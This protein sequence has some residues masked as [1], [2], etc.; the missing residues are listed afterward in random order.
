MYLCGIATRLNRDERNDDRI[1]D[2][3]LYGEFEVFIQSARPIRA[4][5]LRTLSADEKRIAHWY[6]LN[7][8]PQLEPYRR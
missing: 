2:T 8:C 6:I 7:D 4:S 3:D 5:T 1:I